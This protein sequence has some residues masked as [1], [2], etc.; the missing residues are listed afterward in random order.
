MF[1][2]K[3]M[4]LAGTRMPRSIE[5]SSSKV[6]GFGSRNISIPGIVKRVTAA[7][8]EPESRYHCQL[9]RNFVSGAVTHISTI[10]PTAKHRHMKYKV[11]YR[12]VR[13]CME[14][15]RSREQSYMSP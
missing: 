13:N 3:S 15:A 2:L 5:V 7:A 8:E 14:A 11:N 9:P 4:T 10:N 1:D 12:S 6:N